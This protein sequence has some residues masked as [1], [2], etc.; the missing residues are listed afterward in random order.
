MT[1]DDALAKGRHDFA[2]T[3]KPANSTLVISHDKRKKINRERNVQQRPSDAVFIRAPKVIAQGNAPQNMWIWKGLR[4]IGA[5]GK[6]LKGVFFEVESC[7]NETVCLTSGQS[8]SHDEAVKCL[9]LSSA[10]CY[11]SAQGLTLQGIVRL[12][13]TSN[14]H[15]TLRHLYV[16]ASRCASC[17]L[18]E[19]T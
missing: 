11:A 9:R 14:K 5:G 17:F 13:D 2:C 1:L 18:L 10:I 16:G 3:D 7:D 15:F 8:L 6:C 12:E 4:L 19:V